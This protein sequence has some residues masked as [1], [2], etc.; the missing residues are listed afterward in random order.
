MRAI[1][2]IPSPSCLLLL[3][4]VMASLLL[5]GVYGNIICRSSGLQQLGTSMLYDRAWTGFIGFKHDAFQLLR[6]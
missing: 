5:R 2:P 6:P 4:T 3:V 1:L